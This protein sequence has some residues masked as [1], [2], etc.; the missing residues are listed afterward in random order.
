MVSKLSSWSRKFVRKTKSS[1]A[2]GEV[3][4]DSQAPKT[5]HQRGNFS[6]KLHLMPIDM[7]RGLVKKEIATLQYEMI[8]GMN[9]MMMVLI[10]EEKEHIKNPPGMMTNQ[11]YLKIH[12]LQTFNRMIQEEKIPT[13]S[14]ITRMM[15]AG[16]VNHV[17]AQK[18]MDVLAMIRLTCPAY[19]RII[20][21]QNELLKELIKRGGLS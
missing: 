5:E 15:T 3:Q 2:T 9:M 10:A 19:S 8:V 18:A 16:V 14:L 13:G 11:S 7:K 1:Q 20:Y 6:I 21:L 4:L 12:W 17:E